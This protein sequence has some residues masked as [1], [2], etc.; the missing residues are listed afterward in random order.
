[1]NDAPAADESPRNISSTTFAIGPGSQFP[2][3]ATIRVS[4]PPP[5]V[6][7][8]SRSNRSVGASETNAL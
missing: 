1:M 6:E 4:R 7:T 8:T 2:A 3:M 5:N